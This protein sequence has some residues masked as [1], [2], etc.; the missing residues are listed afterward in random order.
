MKMDHL[1]QQGQPLSDADLQIRVP[2]LPA[3][4]KDLTA[5]LLRE[6]MT[7]LQ[8]AERIMAEQEKRIRE[9]EDLASTDALTGLMNRR[10]LEEFFGQ[11]HARIRRG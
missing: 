4:Q 1:F 5:A 3:A 10:G 8:D 7:R 2:E 6:A 11:E 9:L